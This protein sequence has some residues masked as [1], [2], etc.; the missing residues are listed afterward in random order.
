MGSLRRFLLRLS[1]AIHPK[2]AE[3][4]LARELTS[5]LTLLEDDFRRR[6]MSTEEA[7]LAA[8]RAFGGVE[9][10]KESHRDARSFV[11][12]DDVRR[13]LECVDLS[14]TNLPRIRK[15]MCIGVA[16][17]QVA[18]VSVYLRSLGVVGG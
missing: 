12:L 11:W 18:N 1:N 7:K 3:P 8:K 5:H 9:Q 13:D 16:A 2:R 6:G 17:D 14:S 4:D 15:Q 10:A